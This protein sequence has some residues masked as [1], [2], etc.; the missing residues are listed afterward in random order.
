MGQKEEED[1]L[2]ELIQAQD[3]AKQARDRLENLTLAAQM[4]LEQPG[5]RSTFEHALGRKATETTDITSVLKAIR[6]A[7][8]EALLEAHGVLSRNQSELDRLIQ[9]MD[10]PSSDPIPAPAPVSVMTQAPQVSTA[11]IE[12]AVN[13]HLERRLTI[14]CAQF[15][16]NAL[17]LPKRL[18]D[19][20]AQFSNTRVE[21]QRLINE[22]RR[23]VNDLLQEDISAKLSVLRSRIDRTNDEVARAPLIDLFEH[24]IS[25][26]RE[27]DVN[28]RRVVQEAMECTTTCFRLRDQFCKGSEMGQEIGEQVRDVERLVAIFGLPCPPEISRQLQEVRERLQYV[29][30]E[31]QATRLQNMLLFQGSVP[32]L[33]KAIQ[34]LF[35]ERPSHGAFFLS[36]QPNPVRL[37]KDS[38][39]KEIAIGRLCVLMALFIDEDKGFG[40]Q[41]IVDMLSYSGLAQEEDRLLFDYM[42]E[43]MTGEMF[44]KMPYRRGHVLCPTE[45]CRKAAQATIDASIDPEGLRYALREGKRAYWNKRYSGREASN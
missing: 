28:I 11:L 12:Q 23:L 41:T 30:S 5:T 14:I 6:H 8:A 16:N 9:E 17:E 24:A 33:P 21:F 45:A 7:D 1:L 4:I 22:R 26:T 32:E 38:T 37:F 13:D 44:T 25:T 2:L 43:Q 3:E 18:R 42:L 27:Y 29:T 40:Q 36:L 10:V 35:E 20:E 39:T 31:G 15:Y 34:N 19:I